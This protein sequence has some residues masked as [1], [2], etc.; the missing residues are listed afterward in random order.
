M[1]RFIYLVLCTCSLHSNLWR[2]TDLTV[3]TV[4]AKSY[5]WSSGKDSDS[6]ASSALDVK[7]RDGNDHTH[8]AFQDPT[9]ILI[10]TPW[11]V[12]LAT[13]LQAISLSDPLFIQ[14]MRVKDIQEDQATVIVQQKED[15]TK[16]VEKTI[17]F[18]DVPY[19]YCYP[20]KGM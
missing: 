20:E 9:L 2:Y 6:K 13:A 18:D 3:A 14:T 16:S 12:N 10:G 7:L 8:P 1:F 19:T 11:G 15:W 5:T 4:Y 17:K